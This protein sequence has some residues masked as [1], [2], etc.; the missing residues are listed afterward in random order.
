MIRFSIC[1]TILLGAIAASAVS[2]GFAQVSP[3]EI[4][5]PR[6]RAIEQRYLAELTSLKRSIGEAKFPMSFRL[7]RYIEATSGRAGMDT[8]G[9]EFI[10]FR[11]QVVLKISGIYSA[12]FDSEHLDE[13]ARAVRVFEGS[14][15]PILRSVATN[16]PQS[17]ECDGIGF[18][19]IYNTR[20]SSREFD[21]EGREVL[22]LVLSRDDAFAIA[23]ARDDRGWQE[24]LDRSDVYISGKP[25][26]LRLESRRD[27]DLRIGALR[28]EKPV[29]P[30]RLLTSL[31]VKEVPKP[32]VA[33]YTTSAVA[34]VGPKASDAI[35][36]QQQFGTQAKAVLDMEAEKLHPDPDA[37]P[38]FE[39][40]G[41]QVRLH[42]TIRNSVQFDAST[43][44]I[45]RR[46]ARSFD[47]FL[48]PELKSVVK[49]LPAMAGL[50]AYQFSVLNTIRDHDESTEVVD[51][52]CPVDATRSFI[53]NRITS[54][55]L[56]NQ[57]TVLVNG[58]RIGIDLEIVE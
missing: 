33:D 23:D 41:D 50:T 32:D 38:Q 27:Q 46:A 24:I 25:V 54:Q 13:N 58:V 29:A 8:N 53:D 15:L 51:Y 6:S 42:F 4:V 37:A 20:D 9:I 34:A 39:A 36:L 12:S 48:A 30:A 55:Q 56:I 21:F 57:S 31:P 14:I 43:S 19:V 49:R 11:N 44:S 35:R 3:N 52:I 18:E 47:L 5:N 10:V 17:V 40:E 7:A 1:R 26:V 45:Y 22:S 2:A 16:L 28:A